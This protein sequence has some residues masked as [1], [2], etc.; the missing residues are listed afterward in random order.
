[1][2]ENIQPVETVNVLEPRIKINNKKEYAILKGGQQVTYKTFVST[3][4]S[5][6]STQFTCPPPNPN[7]IV[8][9]KVYFK[10]PITI[11]FTGTSAGP[12]SYLLQSGYDAFRA[13][14][15]SQMIST[16]AVSINGT[17]VSINLSDVISGLLRYHTPQQ[18]REF[19]YSLTPSMLDQ[20]QNYS[21][22]ANSIRNPLSQYSD[23]YEMARGGFILDNLQNTTTTA[24]VTAT[25]CEP[26]FLSPMAWCHESEQGFIGVQTMEFNFTYVNNI[27]DK[28]WSHATGSGSTINTIGITLG[29]PSLLFTYITPQLSERI[30]R[31]AMYPYFDVQRYPTSIGQTLASGE[32]AV[33]SSSNIQ[34]NSIPRR[35]YVYGRVS[36]GSQTYMTSDTFLAIE[37]IS[38]N[39]NN[40]SGLLASADKRTLYNI[41]RRNGCNL[42]W[43][44]W[45]GGPT[46]VYSGNSNQGY[47][48]IGSV[49]CLEMG[50]D[51]G[52]DDLN[53]PGLLGT[54]QLQME[55]TLKNVNESVN[56][57]AGQLTLY[58]VTVSEGIFNIEDNRVITQIGVINQQDILM[59]SDKPYIN[60]KD[61]ENVQGGNFFTSM[62]NFG[63]LLYENAKKYL[64]TLR[65]IAK[66]IPMTA[67]YA[68]VGKDFLGFGMKK[69]KKLT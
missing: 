30:P 38:L 10:C 19:D 26:L 20:F 28:I 24:S 56:Y 44:Q 36:N 5:Q 6:T 47:G 64:P 69:H 53:A 12:G 8:D 67:P 4:Y 58:V 65:K 11:N 60:Y 51:I 43:E 34:L 55:V 13:F 59:A 25:L 49:L 68:D 18:M 66:H 52:L 14:P 40:A 31:N 63:H 61:V 48:T 57:T 3:S 16:L 45:S 42:S 39:W 32:I 21:S 29:Q 27:A 23:S 46:Y 62:K 37:K 9:R 17:T 41:S 54:Y 7:V 15:L 35:I 2:S 33:I 50:V 22:G 1:M